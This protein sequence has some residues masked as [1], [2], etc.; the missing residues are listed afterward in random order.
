MSL[1]L[2][3]PDVPQTMETL[4]EQSTS[5]FLPRCVQSSPQES[6][7][8]LQDTSL[9][10]T[11]ILNGDDD[12][13]Y[14]HMSPKASS[15]NVSS[16]SNSS[17]GST[18]SRAE[19]NALKERSSSSS[20]V[21]SFAS[22]V[23]KTASPP[24]IL[25]SLFIENIPRDM[26]FR[27]FAGIFTFAKDVESC[28][29]SPA[30][31]ESETLSGCVVFRSYEAAVYA[32]SILMTSQFYSFSGIAV[33]DN[34]G[35]QVCQGS[36]T[37]S[38][39]EHAEASA[40]AQPSLLSR[41]SSTSSSYHFSAMRESLSQIDLLKLKNVSD[42]SQ[43]SSLYSVNNHFDNLFSHSGPLGDA[44]KPLRTDGVWTPSS[45]SRGPF[46]GLKDDSSPWM[47]TPTLKSS[48]DTPNSKHSFQSL[49]I[50]TNFSNRSPLSPDKFY[51]ASPLGSTQSPR[52]RAFT[53]NV[54]ERS[55]SPPLTPGSFTPTHRDFLYSASSMSPNT[56][57]APFVSHSF[58]QR[59]PVTT[60]VNINPADQNPPCNTIYV[61]NLPPST[62]EDEL[63]ALFST[64]P[65]YKRLCF[66]T[67][68]NGPMC[69]VEFES[70][71]Y[72]TEAL[73]ALQGVCLSSSVK[74]GI[75]LSFSKNPLGVR[76]P[77]SSHSNNRNLHSGSVNYPNLS[78]LNQ[79]NHNDT[80]VP[81]WGT[82][83]FYK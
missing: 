8:K 38:D 30:T 48:T 65:G 7:E 20:R 23:S 81:S 66:R 74:G 57:F 39:A 1:K 18:S 14:V 35:H 73:K 53:A 80:H 36:C 69:F 27:E 71:A 6:R 13:S 41:H 59:A 54:G 51:H 79:N 31:T 76:S 37:P 52:F 17:D 45:S 28:E 26:S 56:P 50:N 47:N 68:G 82:A 29:L 19:G 58:H 49:S 22:R 3:S 42:A 60:P 32:R 46:S 33:V 72:A 12:A 70:I 62:S 67:K 9:L 43:G 63:K 34:N 16:S 11:G 55:V 21:S 83:P 40:G 64:Q 4:K 77:S 61:G 78:L 44:A 25:A 10:P 24:P 2:L 75:R 15:T 5:Y